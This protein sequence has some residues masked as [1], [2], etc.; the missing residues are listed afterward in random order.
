MSKQPGVIILVGSPA[1]GWV[2]GSQPAPHANGRGES[3]TT[4]H[5]RVYRI[6]S[7]EQAPVQDPSTPVSEVDR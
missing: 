2:R 5:R 3:S 4:R 6:G 7:F 1:P